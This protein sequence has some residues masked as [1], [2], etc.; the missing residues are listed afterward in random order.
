MQAAPA[1]PTLSGPKTSATTFYH[2]P[3]KYFY[4]EEEEEEEEA[5]LTC[6]PACLYFTAGKNLK[7]K[8]SWYASQ[9]CISLSHIR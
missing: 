9:D 3:S 6:G 7:V 2:C 4:S 5:K 8:S 1:C